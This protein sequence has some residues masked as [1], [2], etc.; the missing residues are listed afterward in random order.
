MRHTIIESLDFRAYTEIAPQSPLKY[1]KEYSAEIYFDT[2]T[3]ILYLYTRPTKG[4]ENKSIYLTELAA[5]L[6]H[7][8]RG[9][10]SLKKDSALATKTG[11]FI[12]YSFE[13]E[14]IIEVML[15]RGKTGHG[16]Y[17]V[18]ILQDEE[19]IKLWEGLPAS[20]IDK[21]PSFTPY[22][23]WVSAKHETGAPLVKTGSQKVLRMLRPETHPIIF[24]AINKS[25]AVGWQVN[26]FIYDLHLWALRNKTEAFADIWEQ[27]NAEAKATKLREARAIGDI[28]GRLKGKP[29]YHR[30]Y[31]DFRGRKYPASAYLHEQGSDLAKG[32]LLRKEKKA[33]GEAGFFWLLISIATNW[34]GEAGREDGLKTDKLPLQ[35]RF[36]WALDNEEILVSY[37]ENPKVNQGW[38]HADKPWQ[39]LAACHELLSLRVWQTQTTRK[40]VLGNDGNIYLTDPDYLNYEYESH[41]ECFIDGSNNGSQHLSALTRDEVTAPHVNLVP[42]DLPG[43]LYKYVADHVWA[44][45]EKIVEEYTPEEVEK[46]EKIIDNLIEM[47]KQIGLAEP[48]SDHRRE[49][50][51]QIRAFKHKERDF[52]SKCSPVFWLRVTDDKERRKIVKRNVMTLPYGGTAYGLGEQQINDAKKLGINL[53]L[54]MEHRWAAFIGREIFEDC[55]RSLQRPMRLLSV[56]EQAGKRAEERGAF[57]SWTVPITKFPVIQHYTE[58]KVKKIWVQ[59]GPPMGRKK[60]TGYYENTLQLAIA[61]L[62]DVIPSKRKQAQGASPNAIHSLDAAHLAITVSR[63]NFPVTTVHDSFGCLLADMPNYSN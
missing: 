62:E 23:P 5:A 55:K 3:T 29:F 30:Y 19:I 45:L 59:Y 63:A 57:L 61:F 17:V 8:V 33:I 50:I 58:G 56:F 53:L 40:E 39:F 36:E 48:K 22:A 51:D 7:A 11:A 60:S 49:L 41:L 38:M 52:M 32:L 21:L 46:C 28:A 15:G 9:K 42:L 18:T 24:D 16:C 12:L 1:L 37:A 35:S 27:S 14:E 31:Y 25:Q 47:K 4:H 6:G 26:E 43:D 20:N 54:F 44:H 34:A 2:V 10:L 13:E